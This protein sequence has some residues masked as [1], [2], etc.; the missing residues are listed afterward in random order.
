MVQC[1]NVLSQPFKNEMSLTVV[2]GACF[3][4]FF[5]Q[6]V[7]YELKMKVNWHLFYCCLKLTPVCMLNVT[8][9]N[10]NYLPVCTIF[11]K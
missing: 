8:C 1:Q 10:I 2:I 7:L 3:G 5:F 6:M 11:E 4:G 9:D